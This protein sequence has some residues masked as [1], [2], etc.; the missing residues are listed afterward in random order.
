MTQFYLPK[1][2]KIPRDEELGGAEKIEQGGMN[3]TQS[4]GHLIRLC[5]LLPCLPTLPPQRPREILETRDP[6][7]LPRHNS[8]VYC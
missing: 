1:G 2:R 8:R 5:S 3:S 7:T 4:R 6:A